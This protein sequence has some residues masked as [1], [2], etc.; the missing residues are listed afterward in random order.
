MRKIVDN[1]KL[2]AKFIGFDG[3]IGRRD[4]FLNIAYLHIIEIICL[5]PMTWHIF[6]HLE[7]FTD[8]FNV[9]KLYS[10]M[11]PLLLLWSALVTFFILF[12]RISNIIRRT[13][14]IM[15]SIN[16]SLNTVLSILLLITAFGM[17]LPLY[18]WCGFIILN[19]IINLVLIFKKGDIT[20]KY[21]YDF[22]KDF[23]WGAFFGTWL[24]G[25]FN[26]SFK[27]LW[28]LILGL[29]P[30][31]FWF[32]LICGLKG[33]EWA[34]K[35][36]KWES[37][38]KFKRSQDIQTIIFVVLK[39]VILPIIYLTL[40][41]AL[42][43]GLIAI[44]AKETKLHP[45][46]TPPIIEKLGN[47]VEAYSSLYFESYEITEKE[48]KFYI[49]P[50]DWAGYSFKDKKDIFDAAATTSALQKAKKYPKKHFS[51]STELQRTKIY[52]SKN[53][54]L[55]GEFSIDKSMNSKDIDFK[56]AVKAALTAYKFYRPTVK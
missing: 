21:P 55:L 32:A 5:L 17:F 10:G 53:G 8:L 51:K 12:T 26:K 38:E 54:E 35:N 27:P 43:F 31:G 3:V 49:L 20:G 2:N 24:W 9:S 40:I 41:M 33:S 14:D 29:T 22:T 37:D 30:A 48:N 56:T 44:V 7:N 25:L 46:Q 36:K 39:V 23:N 34:Y 18:V 16:N 1:L 13:N 15:G 47:F 6:S 50:S 45:N 52:S 28:M 19:F 11:P 42:I 4:Y